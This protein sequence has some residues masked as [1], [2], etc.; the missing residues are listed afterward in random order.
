MKLANA[1]FFTLAAAVLLAADVAGKWKGN[2]DGGGRETVLTLK[3]D[4]AKVTGTMSG[5]EGKDYPITRGEL[6]GD[7]IS[8]TVASEWQGN[9][10]TLLVKGTVAGDVMK[11]RVEAEGGGWGADLEAR[12]VK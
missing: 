6:S 9:P 2:L 8:L 10:S 1:L 7:A 5:P 3:A 11:L 12:R 4:G